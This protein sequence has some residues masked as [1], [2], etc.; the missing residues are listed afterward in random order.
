ML[1]VT[2][3]EPWRATCLLLAFL[4]LLDKGMGFHDLLEY[5]PNLSGNP[6]KN[7][8]DTTLSEVRVS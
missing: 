4:S 1:T 3:N 8:S 6:R 5:S 7:K 2:W